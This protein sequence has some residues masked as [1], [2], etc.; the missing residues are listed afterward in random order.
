MKNILKFRKVFHKKIRLAR[1]GNFYNK[2]SVCYKNASN[3]T[4]SFGDA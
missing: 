1:T 3:S 2:N 4:P